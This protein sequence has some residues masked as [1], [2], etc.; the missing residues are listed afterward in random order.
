MTF[1]YDLNGGVKKGMES[2]SGD[3]TPGWGGG[4][5]VLPNMGYIGMCCCEGYGFQAVYP[6]I[7]CINQSVWV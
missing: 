2:C 3:Y 1:K 6:R 4:G 5:V 7:G